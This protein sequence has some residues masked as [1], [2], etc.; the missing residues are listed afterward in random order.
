VHRLE[1]L[2]QRDGDTRSPHFPPAAAGRRAASLMADTATP[3]D[4]ALAALQRR[5]RS[6]TI[7][8]KE[9]VPIIAGLPATVRDALV[10]TREEVAFR[11]MC[12]I[13]VAMKGERLDTPLVLRLIREYG[14]ARHLS[15]RER[16]FIRDPAPAKRDALRFC[17]RYEAA[18]TL[19]WA[20]GYVETL[21]RPDAVCDVPRLVATMRDR[22]PAQFVDG[23]RLR[24]VAQILDQADLTHRY[25]RAVIDA[26]VAQRPPP[27]GLHPGVCH[28]RHHA[29][30]WLTVA[31]GQPWDEVN[32]AT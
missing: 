20:L 4:R 25:N 15:P 2:Q 10:R 21:A 22:T 19:L 27:A 31:P 13:A 24:A 7:L 3:R 17:W 16:D 1:G 32:T 9:G 28:E 6:E 18:W 26:L 23:A 12:L 29:L 30:N 11:A 5:Q 14:L 8:A